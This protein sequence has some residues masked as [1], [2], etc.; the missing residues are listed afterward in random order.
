MGASEP[1][2][3]HANEFQ[4]PYEHTHQHWEYQN[5]YFLVPMSASSINSSS[6]M[7]GEGWEATEC[8]EIMLSG[9]GTGAGDFTIL[10]ETEGEGGYPSPG[11]EV[12][13]ALEILE[14]RLS[15]ILV[16]SGTGSWLA[17]PTG[18]L[19]SMPF[20]RV[21][22]RGAWRSGD[23]AGVLTVVEVV[24]EGGGGGGGGGGG[25]GGGVGSRMWSTVPPLVLLEVTGGR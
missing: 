13:W 17:A 21:V 24:E 2:L 5:P 1:L 15:D 20:A 18:S 16:F 12:V 8:G 7:Q 11:R 19:L 10:M 3:T 9:D 4:H 6:M 25:S 22:C 14:E 23:I